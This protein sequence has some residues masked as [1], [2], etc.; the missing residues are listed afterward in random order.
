MKNLTLQYIHKLTFSLLFSILLYFFFAQ[1]SYAQWAATYGGGN[2]DIANS[3]QQTLDGGY[4]IAGWTSSFGAGDYDFWVLKLRQDG[5]IEWQK[6]YGGDNWEGAR[7]I[8]QTIDGG[9]IVGGTTRS[10]GAGNYDFWVLKLDS[11]G[12]IQWQKTYGGGNSE[13]IRSIQQ[14]NDGGYI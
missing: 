13:G 2:S 12:N 10:S 6:T 7:S 3:I 11:S 8:Q 14:T 4:I 5:I 1:P 9:Y